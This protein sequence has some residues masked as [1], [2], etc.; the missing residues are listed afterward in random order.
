MAQVTSSRR[1]SRIR[2][3]KPITNSRSRGRVGDRPG[4]ANRNVTTG[5][6]GRSLRGS[7][8]DVTYA[9]NGRPRTP[10]QKRLTGSAPTQRLSLPP[11][12]LPS[13]S[14]Q[15]PNIPKPNVGQRLSNAAKN[16]KL[17][18]VKLPPGA[19]KV[20]GAAG[21]VTGGVPLVLAGVD[22]AKD[23]KEQIFDRKEGFGSIPRH[24][25][26][27]AK[28]GN[29]KNSRSGRG[30]GRAGFEVKPS[31]SKSSSSKPRLSNIPESEGTGKKAEMKLGYGAG[32]KKPVNKPSTT[33]STKPSGNGNAKKKPKTG[34]NDPRN[35]SYISAAKKL[36]ASKSSTQ[37]DRNKLTDKGM[38][39]WAKANR[40]MIENSGTS[41]QKA[42]LK[43]IDSGQPV[44][45]KTTKPESTK[46]GTRIGN[47]TKF[48][49]ATGN[50]AKPSQ[51]STLRQAEEFTGKRDRNKANRNTG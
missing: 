31:N 38:A 8:A 28:G 7:G 45:A 30:A 51:T 1:R 3:G 40:E 16:L 23:L 47:I 22:I 10:V 33:P 19:S 24:L 46:G 39:I 14:F 27:M 49:K 17:P 18:K 37:K 12:R 20:L 13:G 4:G 29:I 41:K 15:A 36:N 5:R 9:S 32:A 21:R 25:R 26:E 44:R 42:L 2:A 11:S 50:N 6:G 34:A 43:R 35:A 48:K